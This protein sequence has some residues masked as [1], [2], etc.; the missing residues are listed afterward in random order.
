VNGELKED[1][2]RLVLKDLPGVSGLKAL[3][4]EVNVQSVSS[5]Q[6]AEDILKAAKQ[7]VSA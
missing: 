5:Q 7:V 6:K 4:V 3:R 1:I 2:E